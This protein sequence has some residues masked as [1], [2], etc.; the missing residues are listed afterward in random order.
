MPTIN[1]EANSSLFYEEY[2]EGI[3]II[4]IHPPGMGRKVFVYQQ[5]LANHMRVILPD[6]SG[7]GESELVEE[8]VS[9]SFYANEIIHLMD[10]LQIDQAMI[11]G[12]SAGSLIA[13]QLGF[14]YPE[15]VQ[16]IILAGAYP[17]VDTLVGKTLHKMGMYMV[18]QHKNMLIQTIARSHTK[19]QEIKDML[20]Q[21][22][23][24]AN[25]QV[26]YHY[27]LDSLQYHCVEKLDSLTMPLLFMFGGKRDWT[28]GYIKNYKND[29]KH[30]EFYLFKD[31]GHQIPTKQWQTFNEQ[32]IKFVSKK[33]YIG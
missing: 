20:I 9:I 26:W 22:M 3:P 10:A 15:R 27:Y 29:C 18:K 13:Q 12:Y 28:S 19:D 32:I 24:K 4:F 2:G 1:T 8:K 31:E 23:E 33:T 16:L 6:L 14:T 25:S 11:C 7:H 21:H 17:E 5:D 30:A